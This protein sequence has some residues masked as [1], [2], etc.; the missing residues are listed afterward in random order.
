MDIRF[1]LDT[2]NL[3]FADNNGISFY[4]ADITMHFF[5]SKIQ[6]NSDSFIFK[7]DVLDQDGLVKHFNG[8]IGN[9]YKVLSRWNG[10]HVTDRIYDLF[11]NTE[12]TINVSAEYNG[13]I[14]DFSLQFKTIFP[15]KPY[16][17]WVWDDSVWEWKPPISYP[18][19]GLDYEWNEVDQE[20][21]LIEQNDSTV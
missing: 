6:R 9:I 19:D 17:S 3:D 7:Y 18:E 20:W 4:H 1:Y 5:G 16:Q 14:V 8:D 21:S 12:Y 11:P 15:P 13:K 10:L 2:G